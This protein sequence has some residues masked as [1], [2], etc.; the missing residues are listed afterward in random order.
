MTPQQLAQQFKWDGNAIFQFCLE[1][2]IDA[3]FHTEAE[4][5]EKL[6]EQMSNEN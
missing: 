2:L 4:K 6:W 5:L 3:N 1:A